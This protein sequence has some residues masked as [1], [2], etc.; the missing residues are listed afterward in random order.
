MSNN[1][2]EV[3]SSVP[4]EAFYFIVLLLLAVILLIAIIVKQ[5]AKITL[6]NEVSYFDPITEIF[7][8][9]YLYERAACDLFHQAKTEFDAG[10][11]GGITFFSFSMDVD[12][13]GKD[14][15]VL[16]RT[17]A[18]NLRDY[19]SPGEQCFFLNDG[20][21]LVIIPSSGDYKGLLDVVHT[22]TSHIGKFYGLEAKLHGKVEMLNWEAIV[23]Q[24]ESWLFDYL[25]SKKN[26]KTVKESGKKP[27]KI[28]A[29]VET[30]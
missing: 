14:A 26:I 12:E 17:I 30:A 20:R 18:K 3:V 28:P 4:S 13:A 7:N 29:T 15:Q 25:L 23:S 24:N 22:F 21:F 2:F 19:L 5:N 27:A 10:E 16:L 11:P 8:Q 9:K 6:L 1:I